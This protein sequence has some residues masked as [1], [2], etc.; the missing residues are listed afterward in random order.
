[1]RVS[2]NPTGYLPDL[3]GLATGERVLGFTLGKLTAEEI[4]E[5]DSRRRAAVMALDYPAPTRDGLLRH[6]RV[7]PDSRQEVEEVA[8]M[9]GIDLGVEVRRAAVMATRIG[10][11]PKRAAALAGV[12]KHRRTNEQVVADVLAL[13]DR[14]MIES[15][16]ADALNL[17]DRRVREIVRGRLG[18]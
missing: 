6:L 7:Y 17:S 9:Y 14:G 2:R 11:A 18:V 3:L 1:M 4:A 13:N 10:K 12:S 15:A 16:I 5:M 8:A